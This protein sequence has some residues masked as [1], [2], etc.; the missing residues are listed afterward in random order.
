MVGNGFVMVGNGF[1]MVGNGFVMAGNE[2]VKLLTGS[3]TCSGSSMDAY[4]NTILNTLIHRY[5]GMGI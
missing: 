1:V 3:S 5:A 4:A 2:V